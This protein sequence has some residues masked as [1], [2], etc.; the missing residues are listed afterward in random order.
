MASLAEKHDAE[1]VVQLCVGR[2]DALD[3][4]VA[5]AGRDPTRKT[6]NLFS[7]I[8]GRVQKKPAFSVYANGR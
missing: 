6:V 4:Y 5:Y 2:H 3:C 7:D 8:G 1:G